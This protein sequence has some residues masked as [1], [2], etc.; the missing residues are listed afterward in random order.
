MSRTAFYSRGKKGFDGFHW[1]TGEF[2][3]VAIFLF[4]F[5]NASRHCLCSFIILW[6]SLG[7]PASLR[8]FWGSRQNAER[9]EVLDGIA[10]NSKSKMAD[11]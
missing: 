10:G 11:E 6:N 3:A 7:G 4:A 5:L 9:R 1:A 8:D 2:S